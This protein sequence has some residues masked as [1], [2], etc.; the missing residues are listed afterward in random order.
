M[1]RKPTFPGVAGKPGT[2]PGKSQSCGYETPKWLGRC[3]D[4]CGRKCASA[5]C[6]R[7]FAMLQKDYRDVFAAEAVSEA[8]AFRTERKIG[9]SSITTSSSRAGRRWQRL[10]DRGPLIDPHPHFAC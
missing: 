8:T 7:P 6:R 2:D 10:A 4:C 3:V 1:A 5:R 9:G